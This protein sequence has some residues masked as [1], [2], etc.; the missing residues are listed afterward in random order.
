MQCGSWT[1]TIREYLERDAGDRVTMLEL[2]ERA[3]DL[4]PSQRSQIARNE[5]GRIM[6]ELGWGYT[7]FRL[8][9]ASRSFKGY[10]RRPQGAQPA[11]ISKAPSW[12][13]RAT[14]TAAAPG[15]RI[16]TPEPR[17]VV[18]WIISDGPP[19]PVLEDGP[20]R[21]KPWTLLA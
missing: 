21:G 2:M 5:V 8:Q 1:A 17:L 7:S 9:G 16:A 6:R 18:A 10:M 11:R 13:R 20:L 3:L 12:P 19:V 15:T 14:T 4:P